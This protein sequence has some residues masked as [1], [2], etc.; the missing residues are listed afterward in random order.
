[1]RQ[2][3]GRDMLCRFWTTLHYLDET[4]GVRATIKRRLN[5]RLILGPEPT[6]GGH[7]TRDYRRKF[8]AK[9]PSLETLTPKTA[10]K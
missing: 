7:P 3:G 4:P 5:R 9:R 1:M 6:A 10:S 8:G 2:L